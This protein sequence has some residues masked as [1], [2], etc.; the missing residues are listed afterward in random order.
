MI[1]SISTRIIFLAIF[2]IPLAV[3]SY[4]QLFVAT[5]RFE[6]E[7]SVIIS[8]E[9]AG[10]TTLDVSFLGLP[11]SGDDKD[12]KVIAEFVSS[13]DMLKFL[14]EKL[15]LRAHYS[16]PTVDWFY[17]LPN[18]ASF[19]EFHD[20]MAG[21]LTVIYDAD[22]K[23]LHVSVQAF[24]ENFAKAILD[25]VI[26]RSQELIDKLNER[27]TT[28]QTRFFDIKLV[29]SEARMKEAKETL[30]KFQKDNR[31]MT[32]DLDAGVVMANITALEQELS[33]K[34]SELNS[35]ENDLAPTAPRLISLRSDIGAL[36]GQL[37][38]QKERLSGSATSSSISDLDSQYREIQLNLEFVT[39]MY[40][41]NLTQLEQARIEA[42]RR[43]KFLIVVSQPSLADESR[44]PDRPYIII[45][46]AIILLVGFFII[47]LLATIIREH[48]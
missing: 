8:V 9:S 34:R 47:S 27:V 4:Y 14:D 19:E 36:E 25:N 16:A 26:A 40:K 46:A 32:T 28:E 29:E 38:L 17:R 11:S 10:T 18:T 6:S 7:A 41:S 24:D 2:V 31:L 5:D 39:T 15:Q 45:T 12:A 22:S 23:I 3:I 30:L 1:K 35:V 13:R 21:Y 43:L 33:K 20:Y 48:A 44:F 42:S 37:R